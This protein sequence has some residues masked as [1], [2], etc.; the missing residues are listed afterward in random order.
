M[1]TL[2]DPDAAWPYPTGDGATGTCHADIEL[3]GRLEVPTGTVLSWDLIE[4]LDPDLRP[5][6]LVTSW[7]ADD[8]Q[9]AWAR[10]IS[11]AQLHQLTAREAEH[12]GLA[13]GL[14]AWRVVRTRYQPDGRPVETADLIL[15]ADRW[16][17]RLA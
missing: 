11:E 6:H 1:R 8:R 17:V 9:G 14:Y 16:R 5:S 12:L 3:A 2:L 15:P 10:S 4:C 13:T 7:W